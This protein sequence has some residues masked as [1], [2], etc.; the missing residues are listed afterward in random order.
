MKETTMIK[1][2][3]RYARYVLASLASVGFGLT[4]N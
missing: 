4:V 1:L 2:S 3:I